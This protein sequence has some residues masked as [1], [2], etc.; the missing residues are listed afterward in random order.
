M[1][2]FN[3]YQYRLLTVCSPTSWLWKNRM[4]GTDINLK[5]PIQSRP[6]YLDWNRI[7][8]NA[9]RVPLTSGDRTTLTES[10]RQPPAPSI[11]LD[12]KVIPVP[13]LTIQQFCAKY[14]LN[15]EIKGLLENAEF[16]SLG[17]LLE[18]SEKDLESIGFRP[19]HTEELKNALR[20]CLK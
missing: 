2:K 12:G 8:H 14:G 3:R 6:K 1:F 19:D 9:Q 20:K 17:A 16:K 13:P 7:Q 18:V 5:E 15:G 11:S 10:L 4:D